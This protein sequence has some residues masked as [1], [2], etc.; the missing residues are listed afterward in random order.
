M[1]YS[2]V[3]TGTGQD[4]PGTGTGPRAPRTSAQLRA[5]PPAAGD[6]ALGRFAPQSV[7]HRGACWSLPRMSL[8][9]VSPA[10]HVSRTLLSRL[11]DK[12]RLSG[13]SG[14]SNWREKG[15]GDEGAVSRVQ[16]VAFA[17]P[18]PPPGAQPAPLWALGWLGCAHLALSHVGP[19]PTRLSPPGRLTASGRSRFCSRP[20]LPCS[21]RGGR[22]PAGGQ[23]WRGRVGTGP[24]RRGGDAAPRADTRGRL[25][26][27]H[28]NAA[29]GKPRP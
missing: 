2:G 20:G 27:P 14:T 28:S 26:C 5:D 21:G 4:G 7:S 19:L 29:V 9:W 6:R 22:T 11:S 15:R 25:R 3:G 23:V 8:L 13:G 24:A 17:R 10:S 1:M 18:A 12:R 16:G